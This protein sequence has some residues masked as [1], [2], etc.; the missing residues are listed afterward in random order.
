[1]EL[2]EIS[3]LDGERRKAKATTTNTGDEKEFNLTKTDVYFF[4]DI[5]PVVERSV[6][7]RA[8]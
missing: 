3:F 7:R 6:L 2:A 5:E 4:E 8:Y 1:V